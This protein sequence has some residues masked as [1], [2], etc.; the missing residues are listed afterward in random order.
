MSFDTKFKSLLILTVRDSQRYM[1]LS[2][3]L[4]QNILKYMSFVRLKF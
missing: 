3:K 1:C 2:K 4:V